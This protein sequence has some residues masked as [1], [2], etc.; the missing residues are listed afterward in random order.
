MLKAIQQ[1]NSAILKFANANKAVWSHLTPE[2]MKGTFGVE[3]DDLNEMYY[4]I[5]VTAI[6]SPAKINPTY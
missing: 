2:W 6:K 1:Q 5:L 3:V 4:D